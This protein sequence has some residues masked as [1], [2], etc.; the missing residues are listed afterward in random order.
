MPIFR[1]N[2]MKAT[3]DVARPHIVMKQFAGEIL[4]V[5]IVNYK[6]GDVPPP[7]YHPNDEQWIYLLSGKLAVLLGDETT[8]AES[9]DLVYVPRNTVHGI[10]VL[11][12]ECV[13]FTCKN[14]S[15]TGG[16]SEDYTGVTNLGELI[17][18]LANQN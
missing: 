7:H 16:L 18:K 11:G 4:K 9:G 8:T 10:K 14:K 2:E 5:G 1:K 6:K 12:D 13:F 3:P 15:G 17:E